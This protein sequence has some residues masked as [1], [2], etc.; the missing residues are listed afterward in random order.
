MMLIIG[1]LIFCNITLLIIN[2][3]E[4]RD[5]LDR[6]MARNLPEYKDN[7]APEDNNVEDE[8]DTTIPLE[9]AENEFLDD[10]HGQTN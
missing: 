3:I 7:H 1:L 4:R 6:L 9:E 10:D 2:Y 5:M 8:A